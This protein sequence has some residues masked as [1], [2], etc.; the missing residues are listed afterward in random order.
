MSP[1]E[2]HAGGTG[3]FP[4]FGSRAGHTAEPSGPASHGG[5]PDNGPYLICL[6]YAGGTASVYRG[7][8]REL[9]ALGWRGRVVPV[10]LPG[11]GLRLRERPYTSMRQLSEAVAGAVAD[12]FLPCDYSLFGHSMGALLAYEVACALRRGGAAGPRHLFVSGSRAPHLYGNR[13]D[14][15]LSDDELFRFVADLGGLGPE[16]SV[17]GAYFHQRL[18]T[19]RADLRACDGYRWQPRPPLPCPVTA[20]SG[21]EDQLAPESDVEAW[22]PYTSGSFLRRHLPGGHFFLNGPARSVLLREVRAELGRTPSGP[23]PGC[24]ARPVTPSRNSA[25]AY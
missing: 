11:R 25:W 8:Q 7:W 21:A 9:A 17:G 14:H 3:W 12:R 18:P 24:A 15:G 2:A 10:Q 5:G 6:S 1:A 16:P 13:A 23:G 22:R 19:L 20:F 4:A